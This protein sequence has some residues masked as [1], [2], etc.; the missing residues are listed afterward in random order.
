MKG[1]P[2]KSLVG[3]AAEPI[4]PVEQILVRDCEERT[5]QRREHRQLVIRPLDR[6]ERGANRL[7]LFT[8]VEG[9]SADEHVRDA[10]C[11]ERLEIWSRDV[12]LP[13][14]KAPESRQTCFAVTDNSSA[15]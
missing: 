1:V 4:G 7:N 12:S 5:P 3:L 14:D 13:A 2:P 11:F 6:G 10:A 9:A 8:L 15:P